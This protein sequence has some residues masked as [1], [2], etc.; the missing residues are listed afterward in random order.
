M[1]PEHLTKVQD[2]SHKD[3]RL[4]QGL[5][6]RLVEAVDYSEDETRLVMQHTMTLA[7]IADLIVDTRV[8]ISELLD[9]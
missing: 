1:I 9:I 5:Y 8:A 3:Q 4:L 2:M 6:D 7:D